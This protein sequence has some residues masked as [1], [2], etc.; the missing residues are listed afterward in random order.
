MWL[1][2][3]HLLTSAPTDA[4]ASTDG[5]GSDSIPAAPAFGVPPRAHAHIAVDASMPAEEG[6]M[7]RIIASSV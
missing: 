3:V 1:E 5:V 2:C 7:A 6:S 4:A